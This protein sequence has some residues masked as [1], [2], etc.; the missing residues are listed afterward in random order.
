MLLLPLFLFPL[1]YMIPVERYVEGDGVQVSA[2]AAGSPAE[3]AG[4]EA[5]DI[6]LSVDGEAVNSFDDMHQAVDAKVGTEVTLLILRQPQAQFETTF[7]AVTRLKE[8]GRWASR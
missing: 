4:L 5:R 2:V 6:I 1:A 8:R 7:H 3:Y